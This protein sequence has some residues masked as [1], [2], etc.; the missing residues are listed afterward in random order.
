LLQNDNS[1]YITNP[2]FQ[3]I[4]TWVWNLFGTF[5]I[6]IL[7]LILMPTV[8]TNREGLKANPGLIIIPIV[9]EIILTGLIPIILTLI[10]KN[11]LISIGIQKKRV[12]ESTI[13]SIPMVIIYYV[14]LFLITGSTIEFPTTAFHIDTFWY[15]LLTIGAIFAYGPLEAFFV[16]WLI[17]KSDQIFKSEEKMFSKGLILTIV[18][19][20]VLHSFSQGL[21][22]ITIAITFLGLGLIYKYTKNSIGPMISW[23]IAKE[24]IWFLIGILLF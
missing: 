4:V 23:T 22:S 21:N 10:N 8:V 11:S 9:S 16:I 13:L 19:Y 5:L 12:I 18:I 1:K 24:Y 17:V 7:L 15:L 6:T 3:V 2:K 20:G 14:L